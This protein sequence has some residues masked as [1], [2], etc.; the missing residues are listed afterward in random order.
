MAP[1]AEEDLAILK[2]LIELNEAKKFSLAHQERAT[3]EL[4][5][6]IGIPKE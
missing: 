4:K 5:K 3:L 6:F 2:N 1:K